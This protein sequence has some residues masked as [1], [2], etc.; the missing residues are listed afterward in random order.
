[1]PGQPGYLHKQKYDTKT[2]RMISPSISNGI[3]PGVIP[4]VV[5]N[6]QEYQQRINEANFKN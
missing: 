2:Q 5:P 6:T 3:I 4:A 1:M